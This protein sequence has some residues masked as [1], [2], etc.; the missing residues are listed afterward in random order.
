M[1]FNNE[2]TLP[3]PGTVLQLLALWIPEENGHPMLS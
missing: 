3:T 2:T 1:R